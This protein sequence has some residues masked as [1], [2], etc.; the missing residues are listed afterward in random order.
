MEAPYQFENVAIADVSATDEGWTGLFAGVDGQVYAVFS[1]GTKTGLIGVSQATLDAAV[2]TLEASIATK[3]NSTHTHT[4]TDITSGT[5]QDARLSA[6]VCFLNSSPTFGGNVTAQRYFVQ[7]AGPQLINFFG[8][9]AAR[10]NGDTA[11]AQIYALN[12][13]ATN[14]GLGS[15]ASPVNTDLD[16][17]FS[18][19]TYAA[20]R[21]RGRGRAAN[22]TFGDVVVSANPNVTVTDGSNLSDDLVVKGNTGN[23]EVNRGNLILSKMFFAGVFT[24]ATLPSPAAND[25]ASARV[26]DAT[27]TTNGSVAAGGGSGKTT[28]FSN[29]TNW[30]I[31]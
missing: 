23:V 16:L 18:G 3:A 6:N 26:T 4:A 7:P 22:V 14:P 8:D 5:L 24:V 1:N 25:G 13:V 20:G 30:I 17:R 15:N 27:S 29:G 10:N 9:L 19:T 2:D 28:V 31:K 11:F 21:V 12:Y